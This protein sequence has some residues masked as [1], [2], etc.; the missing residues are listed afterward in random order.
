MNNK[1]SL[2]FGLIE[3]NTKLFNVLYTLLALVVLAS[4]GILMTIA[5]ALISRNTFCDRH[6][7]KLLS[8]GLA[9]WIFILYNVLPKY[10]NN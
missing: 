5:L 4:I 7:S 6:L 1:T 9:M 2:F 10:K 3:M 8:L